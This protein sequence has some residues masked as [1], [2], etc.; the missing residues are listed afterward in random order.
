MCLVAKVVST[1]L[2]TQNSELRT[3]KMINV[4]KWPA[5]NY[6]WQGKQSDSCQL[7]R[8]LNVSKSVVFLWTSLAN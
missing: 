6:Q 4:T 2:R 1:Q 7:K 3:Q 8:S 5:F